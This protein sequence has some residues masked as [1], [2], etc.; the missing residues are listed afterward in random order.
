MQSEILNDQKA[1]RGHIP[2]HLRLGGGFCDDD[3]FPQFGFQVHLVV[4]VPQELPLDWGCRL[5]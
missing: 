2:A 3:G 5:A 4:S 1:I